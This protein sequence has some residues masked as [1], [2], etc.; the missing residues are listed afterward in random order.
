LPRFRYISWAEYGSLTEALAEKIRSSKR[1]F[2]I[3][4][5]IARGGI[6]VAMVVSDRLGIKFDTITVKS[7][8]GIAKRGS[9]R[10]LTKVTEV[11]RGKRVLVVDDLVDQGDTMNSVQAML[12]K[13]KTKTVQTAVLFKKPWSK[14][15]PDYFLETTEEWI[16][17]P[18]ELNEVNTLRK[19]RNDDSLE[20]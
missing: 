3:V 7:Y 4:V 5:G 12:R 2:D 8:S 19:A 9:V 10:I 15:Q 14:A 20:C 18:F 6:P 17:F 13:H 1:S 16:V 11:I